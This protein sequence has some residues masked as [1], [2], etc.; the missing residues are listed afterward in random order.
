MWNCP[1][2]GTYGWTFSVRRDEGLVQ[3]ELQSSNDAT[4]PL[5]METALRGPGAAFEYRLID[6]RTL[7][8]DR[9]IESPDVGDLIAIL[10]ILRRLIEKRF[11]GLPS[12]A[13]QNLA[14]LSAPELEDL[15]VRVLDARS[16]EE[17]L[18]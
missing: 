9:L 15:S 18:G 5:R 8:G 2:S 10:T 11:G 14:A 12:W 1:G 17:L 4:M 16:A 7:D 13:A 6:I 3:V